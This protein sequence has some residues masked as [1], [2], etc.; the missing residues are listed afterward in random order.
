L[1]LADLPAQL[2]ADKAAGEL[3]DL[4]QWADDGRLSPPVG[5]VSASE[6]YRQ[7]LDCALSGQGVGKTLLRVFAD[8]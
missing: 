6:D 2:E 1:P 3:A 8:R 4:R 7:A 5:R